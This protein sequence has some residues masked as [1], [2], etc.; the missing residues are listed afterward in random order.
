M[1]KLVTIYG[2]SGFLGRYIAR[3]MAKE[4]WRVRVAV[5]RPNEAMFVRPYGAVGQVEPVLCN[6]RDDNSVRAVMQGADAVVNCVGTFD[7]KGRNNFDAVQ[8]EGA[9]RIARIAAETG[10]DRMVHTSAIGADA[11]ADS[12]YQRTK[13]EGEAAVLA[14]MPDA[15]ILRPSIM[16]GQEDGF[17]NR[18]ASMSRLGPVLPVV[19]A[20]TKFQPVY[21]DDVAKAAVMG[22][23]GEAS[24]VYELGGPEVAT[25]RAL[26]QEMLTVIRRRKLI[27]NVP[28]GVAHM[29]AWG[30]DAASSLTLGLFHNGILT[31]DQVKS[32]KTDNVVSGG[33]KGLSDLGIRP[34][35]TEAVLS[36]YLWRFRP[37]GQYDAI[38]ESAGKLGA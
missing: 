3:R 36:D 38:K 6:I 7:A 25:F 15:M 29:M 12:D 16:F 28:F 22:V 2:G 13:A 5:R 23:K 9:E 34:T 35:A 14:H 1:S 4:G 30:F 31:R 37:S 20:D 27:L 11:A 10:V 21:V 24:G 18:F 8:V 32:L 33:A 26:M 17:F 19:G